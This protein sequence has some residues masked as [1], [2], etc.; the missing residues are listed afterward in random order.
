VLLSTDEE[1]DGHYYH[2][3]RDF[4]ATEYTLRF[5]EATDTSSIE[6]GYLVSDSEA[7]HVT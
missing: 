3:L 5:D 1:I 2:K 7:A 4:I 6:D